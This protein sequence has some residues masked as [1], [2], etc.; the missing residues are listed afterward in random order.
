MCGACAFF[1][2]CFFF[3][4]GAKHRQGIGMSQVEGGRLFWSRARSAV[5]FFLSIGV[6]FVAFGAPLRAPALS[7]RTGSWGSLLTKP[8]HFPTVRQ[9]PKKNTRDRPHGHLL[10]QNGKKK[11][12]RG[13]C[14]KGRVFFFSLAAFGCK[15]EKR[16]SQSFFVAPLCSHALARY[17]GPQS[18]E[19]R[20][21]ESALNK[22]RR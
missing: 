2:F 21:R 12:K 5:S 20:Q 10:F 7:R 1:P 15:D 4:N 8:I 9:F 17:N 11:E 6:R 3:L 16:T 19:P 13:R 14:A 22:E 18:I